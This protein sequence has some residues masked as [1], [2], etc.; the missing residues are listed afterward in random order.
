MK[1]IAKAIFVFLVL[2]AGVAGADFINSFDFDGSD[3][4]KQGVVSV[5]Q[6]NTKQTYCK[7]EIECAM[8]RHCE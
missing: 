4:Q 1:F 5:V 3:M 8:S 2:V 6:E 7:P